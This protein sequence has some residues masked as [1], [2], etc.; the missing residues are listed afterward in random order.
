M[1]LKKII[2]VNSEINFRKQLFFLG[3]KV[4]MGKW[5]PKKLLALEI[6]EKAVYGW[7]WH[8][9]NGVEN[10]TILFFKAVESSQPWHFILSALRETI[11]FA[12]CLKQFKFCFFFLLPGTKHILTDTTSKQF[13]LW[14][15]KN[16][17]V[18]NFGIA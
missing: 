12:N 7:T 10:Q 6:K 5:S 9:E 8:M 18:S 3:F 16:K 15:I 11:H 14:M 13:I 2:S 4:N 17:Q 1:F